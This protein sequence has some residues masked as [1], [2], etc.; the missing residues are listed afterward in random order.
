MLTLLRKT[1]DLAIVLLV[2]LLLFHPA[3]RAADFPAKVPNKWLTYPT[4]CGL[5]YGAA[6]SGAGGGGT[7]NNLSG[8]Q[9]LAG[10]LGLLAGYTCPIGTSSFWFVEGIASVSRVNGGEPAVGFS[11]AGAASFEQRIGIGAPWSVIQGLTAALPSLGGVAV[12]SVEALPFGA[13]AGPVNPYVFIGV[14]ERDISASLGLQ[15]GRAW[16]VAP[17]IGFGTLTRLSNGMV[18]DGWVK[19]QPASTKVRIGVTGQ[20]FKTGD[21]VGIGLALKL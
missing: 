18:L 15:I 21:F 11:L 17:E 19:Y 1:F 10:D 6:F 16:V 7:T 9:V 20:E 5:Y 3:A 12:P 2:A 8:A 13:T 4:G 14:N